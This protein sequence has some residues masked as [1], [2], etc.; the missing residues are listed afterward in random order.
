MALYIPH[1]IFHLARLVWRTREVCQNIFIT[2]RLPG[3]QAIAVAQ[4]ILTKPATHQL[5]FNHN[6]YAY[7]PITDQSGLRDTE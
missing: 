2:S 7:R 5:G 1:S 6:D 4:A 3:L